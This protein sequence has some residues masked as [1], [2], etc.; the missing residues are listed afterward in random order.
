MSPAVAARALLSPAA[1]TPPGP[2][3]AAALQT[4]GVAAPGGHSHSRLR[5]ST[6]D[7]N[8]GSAGGSWAASEAHRHALALSRCSLASRGDAREARL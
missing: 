3:S 8:G 2:P 1:D 7:N 6:T 5:S 4:P